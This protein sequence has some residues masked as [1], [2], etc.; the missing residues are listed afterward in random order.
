[1]TVEHRFG[2]R[3]TDRK[4]DI[5]SQYLTFFTTALR[6]QNFQLLY[7]DGFAGSGNRLIERIIAQEEPLF[8]IE[9]RSERVH[10]PGSA[11]IAL[12][13][14]PPFNRIALIERHAKRFEELKKL[15]SHY[16]TVQVD[17]LQGDA[18][19]AIVELCRTI[20]WR[21]PNAPGRGIRA[22][23]FL[24]P[25]GMNLAFSTLEAIAATKAI[26]VWYLFP[27]SGVCRQA[28]RDGGKLAPYKRAAI[29][30]ILGTD[31]WENEFYNYP[32]TDDLFGHL[33]AKHRSADIKT[34]EGYIKK[35]LSLVFPIVRDPLT[36]KTDNGSPLYSLF[37][38]LSNSD[39]KAIGLALKGADHILR[40]GISSQVR[41]RK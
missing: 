30:R 19:E 6:A 18:N 32:V 20:P 16:P 38:A 34:I 22:V 25:Y 27:I 29:T 17:L 40:T 13:T 2:G 8:G 1:M 35:R 31:E 28:S 26:D 3:W 21:G 12:E 39:P 11:R 24:D 36:L 10:A 5:L 9:N 4:L 41:P 23:L 37:F 14:N 15:C 33:T 7:I